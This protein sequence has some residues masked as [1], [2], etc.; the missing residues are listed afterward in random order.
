[1]TEIDVLIAGGGPVG[2]SMALALRPLGLTVVVADKAPP[3]SAESAAAADDR[4]IALAAGTV[5]ILK[6]MDAWSVLGE[7]AEPIHTVHVSE[8]GA[9]GQTILDDSLNNGEALGQVVPAGKLLLS[10]YQAVEAEEN[11]DLLAGAAVVA[12]RFDAAQQRVSITLDNE[13]S[14][15]AGVLIAADG[16]DSP[17]RGLLGLTAKDAYYQQKALV[18][19][20]KLDAPHEG[21]AWERF[22]KLGP[23]ALLPMRENSAKLVWTLSDN[24]HETF[25]AADDRV[26]IEAVNE[27][28]RGRVHV[29]SIGRRDSYPLRRLQMPVDIAP[30]TVFIGNAAH[31]M[32]PVAAQGLNLGLRDVA[33]LA[34]VIADAQKEE[35]EIGV[36]DVLQRYSDWRRGDQRLTGRFTHSL[37]Q[38]FASQFPPMKWARGL[39]MAAL[40]ITPPAKRRFAKAAMGLGGKLPRL[41]RG[42]RL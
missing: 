11:I 8:V 10:L 17:I 36:S 32:H 4:A 38:L 21:I 25:S 42:A 33:V 13:Q 31:T 3:L 24:D 12:T 19:R 7:H 15:S 26:L 22:T 2:L 5:R 34:E 29:N 40:N 14:Y 37:T 41:A 27:A 20:A 9:F 1:M 6:S 35:W 30:H 16:T 18:T 28:F 23:L 39:G